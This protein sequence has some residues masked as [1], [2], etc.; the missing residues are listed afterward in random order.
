MPAISLPSGGFNFKE[1]GK[2]SPQTIRLIGGRMV[3]LATPGKNSP[4]TQAK[5][6]NLG[7]NMRDITEFQ[8][9]FKTKQKV[10][11]LYGG[12]SEG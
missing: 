12:L 10:K 5:L 3:T 9:Q 2:S 1:K 7:P 11:H 6:N 8:N 4:A